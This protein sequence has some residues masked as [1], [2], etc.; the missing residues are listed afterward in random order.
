[1]WTLSHI[2]Q[3]TFIYLYQYT[4]TLTH[5]GLHITCGTRRYAIT[6]LL[7]GAACPSSL[8]SLTMG[9]INLLVSQIPTSV[10]FFE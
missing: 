9:K 2:N 4:L 5:A 8:S 1:M 6:F 3:Y 10:F 7:Y